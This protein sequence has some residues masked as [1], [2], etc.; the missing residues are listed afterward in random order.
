MAG[1]EN[2]FEVE[3]LF[4]A[5]PPPTTGFRRPTVLA[6]K[7]N[8][9]KIYSGGWRVISSKEVKFLPLVCV[10]RRDISSGSNLRGSPGRTNE[11]SDIG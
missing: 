6:G 8:F 4:P 1:W 3:E 11:D 7:E 2:E 10:A 9:R 5:Y